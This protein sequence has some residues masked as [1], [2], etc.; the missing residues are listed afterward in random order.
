MT[1]TPG[2]DPSTAI[3][4]D[5]SSSKTSGSTL[6]AQRA[7]D[8]AGSAEGSGVAERGGIGDVVPAWLVRF[9]RF[10]G[11]P[12][13][14][15][16][17]ALRAL[18]DVIVPILVIRLVIMAFAWI[19]LAMFR[20]DG[21]NEGLGIWNHWDGPHFLELAANGY[22]PPSEIYRI[23]LFPL[24]PASIA[25][26]EAFFAPLDA[27]MLA[28][29]I[30]TLAAGLGLYALVR[31]DSPRR[32]ARL[33]VVAMVVF[34]TA[35]SLIAPYS[36]ALFL[37]TTVWAFVAVRRGNMAAAGILGALAAATRIQGAFL[38]VPLG[39]EYLMVRRRITWDVFWIFFVGVGLLV[40]LAINQYY[41]NDPLYFLAIQKD[42]F[43]VQN[44]FPWDSVGTLIKNA[45]TVP[46]S[47]SWVTWYLAPLASLV[48]LAVVTVWA[49]FSKHSR[50]SYA[51]YT[52]ISLVAFA[53]LSWPISV[54][55]YIMGVFPIFIAMG[56]WSRWPGG[57]AV[58][59]ASTLLL[60]AFTTLFVM[61]HWAF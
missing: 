55:R 30:A 56:T 44:V 10:F 54:P 15:R 40:Y 52:A 61:G 57:Q 37:A 25:V 58:L 43:F 34:P 35:Y 46:A 53:S 13:V 33:S 41:F 47:E 39:I 51:I 21:M 19:S 60:A 48:L 29:L 20:P 50:P 24:Y 11:I 18:R 27:G 36:E 8:A 7:D 17:T 4:I 42:H 12:T 6:G 9:A 16:L 28:S 3:E 45:L 38:I 23:V 59:T 5:Q 22:G 14:D 1:T 2:G 31:L 26:L 49:I 32:L